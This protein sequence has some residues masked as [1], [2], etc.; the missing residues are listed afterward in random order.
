MVKLTPSTAL[1]HP[2]LRPHNEPPTAKCF[3]RSH[4]SNNGSGTF[5]LLHREPAPHAAPVVQTVL[6]GL[7]GTAVV[8]DIR[9]TGV[10]ATAL[11]EGGKVRWLAGDSIQRRLGAQLGN[12][13]Q[14]RF[15]VGVLGMV[16]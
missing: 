12:G 15:G 10:E 11:R 4:T 1:T 8:H 13:V 9:A 16:R 5:R 6:Y 2:C 3:F 14:Q 7:L